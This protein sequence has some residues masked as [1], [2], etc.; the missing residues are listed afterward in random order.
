MHKDNVPGA[1]GEL[2][3]LEMAAIDVR[4]VRQEVQY[5]LFLEWDSQLIEPAMSI[6]QSASDG[7]GGALGR[8]FGFFEKSTDKYLRPSDSNSSASLGSNILHT[9]KIYLRGRCRRSLGR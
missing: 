8:I 1:A 4:W 6:S 5:D 2:Y 3:H 9:N 7:G